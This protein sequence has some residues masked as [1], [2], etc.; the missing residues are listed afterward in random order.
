MKK[1]NLRLRILTLAVFA[2][3][4]FNAISQVGIGTLTPDASAML[5][6]SSTEKGLLAPRMTSAQRIAIAS[7]IE[8]LLVYD[9]TESAFYFY[10]S[11]AWTKLGSESRNNHKIIKSAADLSAELTAGGGSKY[12]L[13]S[14][15]LYEINGT[16]TLAQSIDLNNAY[17]AGIDTNEDVLVKIGGT[18]FVGNTG[19]SIKNVTLSAPGGTI[20]NLSG[21]N[22]ENIIFRDCFVANSGS[23][24]SINGYGLVFLSV[25]QFVG[26]TAGITYS[27]ITDL[28]M[29]NT[30]WSASNGGTYETF[31]GTFGFIEKQGGFSKV[32]GSA[33][34]VDFS[35]NPVVNE[36]VLTG[37]SFSGTSAQYV[38]GYTVGSY[39]GFNFNNAWTVNCPGIPVESDQVASGNIYYDGSITNGFGQTFNNGNARNL[40]GN[41][42]TNS[43]TAVNLMRVSSPVDNRITYLG[44]K[45]RTFQINASLSIRGE[46]GLGNYYA[47][48]IRKNGS[49][50]LTETNTLMRVNNVDDVSSNSITG[51]VELDPNDYI[52]IWVKRLTGTG[53]T[54]IAVFSLNLNMK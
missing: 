15:I 2:S 18:M 39:T 31:T 14:N 21:S 52:E 50:T 33:I 6:L 5:D 20:F 25:V 43:T 32:D 19:G 27:N 34:G 24:G 4:S 26:N 28:L 17:I 22:T 40:A 35:S 29:S 30:G 45:T 36:G 3:F 12:L 38:K 9:I 8:G 23:V 7:P 44:K 13:S 46:N 48:F 10:K 1:L 41:S 11:S 16:I 54:E 51:T 37:T 47:F 42:N 53:S 49:T